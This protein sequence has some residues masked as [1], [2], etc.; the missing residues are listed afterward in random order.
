MASRFL[1]LGNIIVA[2]SS[3]RRGPYWHL[4]ETCLVSN[5]YSAHIEAILTSVSHCL[6]LTPSTL[7]E[8][9]A[10]QMG[11]S[12]V[13]SAEG[14]I[15]RIPPHLIGFDDRKQ[16]AAFT[17]S[18]FAP[19]YVMSQ[20]GP[21]FE[22]HC[23]L[24]GVS[25]E[26]IFVEHF[27]DIVGASAASWFQ[28]QSTTDI[29][30]L[31][32]LL[33][34][35]PYNRNFNEDFQ[36]N[37]DGVALAIVRSLSDQVILP[38]GVIH[39]TLQTQSNASA[40]I[41]S[42]VVKHR[43]NDKVEFHE[44]NLP[45]FSVSTVCNAL[46]WV[47]NKSSTTMKAMTYHVVHGLFAALQK[48]PVVNEQLR[49]VNAL[50]VWIS[51]R[52]EDFEDATILHTLVQRSAT[53]L[54][55]YDLAHAAQSMLEWAFRLYRKM[56]IKDTGFSNILIRICSIAHDYTR[57]RHY[58]F[59]QLGTSLMEWIDNQAIILSKTAVRLQVLRALPTW[60]Y[61][62]MADLAQIAMEQSSEA[63][64]ALLS[65]SRITYNKFRLVRRLRDHAAQ[66]GALSP[67][68]S[69]LDFWRLKDCIPD[70]T[71]LQ[72][73]DVDAFASLLLMNHGDIGGLSSD[74]QL[75]T[76][77]FV[78]YRRSV[79]RKTSSSDMNLFRE[80][81]LFSLLQLLDD[82][83]TYTVFIA[84]QTLRRAMAVLDDFQVPSGSSDYASE[85][86]YLRAFPRRAQTRPLCKLGEVL[87]ADNLLEYA[88]SFNQW[89]TIF[90]SNI[91][92]CLA[93]SD[94]IF[95]QLSPILRSNVEFSTEYLPILIQAML[96]TEI[97]D[98]KYTSKEY[99]R[100]LT[101]YFTSVLTSEQ[102]DNACRRS[103]IDIVLH[104]RQFPP[105]KG[106]ALSYNRWLDLDYMLLAKNAVCCGAYTTALL[107]LELN[108]DHPSSQSQNSTSPEELLYEIYSHIDEPDGF[109]GIKTN[110]L[111][112]FLVRRFHHERQWEKALQFHGAEVEA[113][114][115]SIMASDGLL[116]SFSSFGFNHLVMNT[117]HS[118]TSTNSSSLD[119]RLGWRTETWDLPERKGFSVGSSLYFALRALH[120]ERNP[121]T[122]DTVIQKGFLRTMDRLKNLGSENMAETREIVR[123]IMCLEQVNDWMKNSTQTRLQNRAIQTD[124]W[125][126][127][128]SI[129]PSFE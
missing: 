75:H 17:L 113:D 25:P 109:Y 115:T 51:L 94:S 53:L 128:F 58:D 57:S 87:T 66:G 98:G 92:D 108:V 121:R 40:Q 46:S 18:A 81:T 91:S 90:S 106:D 107:F 35:T 8:A 129:N 64:E 71:E 4:I 62:P 1:A 12:I 15:G 48:S 111:H 104:L 84:Y 45:A 65:D 59:K 105:R 49:L 114:P 56:K 95:A 16:S 22:A 89:I 82:R 125:S 37:A 63:L 85:L 52:H 79:G 42:E 86:E 11:F 103:V 73:E 26:D 78:R 70:R 60:P 38:A 47:F 28:E 119:Y 100:L 36:R 102:T 101:N 54:A 61:P 97:K 41:F 122:A 127:L 96:Q 126:E 27:G 10:S 33:R 68:F 83:H 39:E 3:V 24:V 120:R 31:E 44:A 117:L 29:N 43:L 55:E 118:S 21:R 14:D 74:S 9:Y 124:E 13:R 88:A 123:E 110:N 20:N 69:P 6:D 19:T 34:D 77:I 93:T 116:Q 5:Q 72:Q 112:R 32:N 99:R 67:Q 7:F 2:S 80:I 50:A 30:E 23:N 76:S